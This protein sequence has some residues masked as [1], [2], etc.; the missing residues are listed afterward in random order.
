M[1]MQLPTCGAIGERRITRTTPSHALVKTLND[2]RAAVARAEAS[3]HNLQPD[4]AA[5]AHI[6]DAMA[7]LQEVLDEMK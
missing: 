2:A 6:V 3:I 7:R 4:E 1:L 5:R